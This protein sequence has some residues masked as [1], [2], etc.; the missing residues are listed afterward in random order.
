MVPNWT[1]RW[2]AAEAHWI[3]DQAIIVN[4]PDLAVDAMQGGWDSPS[5]SVL[6]GMSSHDDAREM[7]DVFLTAS[8]ELG[9]ELPGT[10]EASE[11]LVRV[12]ASDILAARV[13]PYEGARLI[14]ELG[15]ELPDPIQ[16]TVQ[17]FAVLEYDYS[18]QHGP[19]RSD[20]DADIIVAAREAAAE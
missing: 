10:V 19:P 16:Q 14:S 7:R 11:R 5:L 2:E 12:Y 17:T 9:R 20:V 1:I 8:K 6:A 3:I 15:Y 18:R 13:S 4:L